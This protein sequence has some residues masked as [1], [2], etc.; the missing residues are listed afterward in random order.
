MLD[1]VPL[2]F[3]QQQAQIKEELNGKD[4]SVIFDGTTRLGEAMATVVRFISSD[5]QIQQRLIHFQLIV[6]SMSGTSC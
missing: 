1:I 5:W 4:L 2:L 3:S 6:R